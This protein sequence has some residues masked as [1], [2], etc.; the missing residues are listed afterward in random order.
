MS[1]KHEW[2][3][4]IPIQ[5]VFLS[6]SVLKNVYPQGV[7]SFSARSKSRARQWKLAYKEFMENPEEPRL[8]EEWVRFVLVSLDFEP[9]DFLVGEAISR[10]RFYPIGDGKSFGPKYILPDVEDP[11]HYRLLVY[12]ME[13]GRKPDEI[14]DDWTMDVSPIHYV[15]DEL[16]YREEKIALLTNGEDWIIIYAPNPKKYLPGY[17][18]FSA[19]LF[20]ERATEDARDIFCDFLKK[21]RFFNEPEYTPEAMLET[22]LEFQEEVTN[23]LGEQVRTSVEVFLRSLDRLDKERGF[24]VLQDIPP[25]VLYESAL[26][27]M[28]R[29][30]ILLYAEERDLMPKGNIYS[31]NYAITGLAHRL[32]EESVEEEKMAQS[33]DAYPQ[34]LA[35]FRLLYAGL[36]DSQDPILPYG[37]SLLDPDRFPF[38]EGRKAGTSWRDDSTLSHPY[39]VDNRTIHFILKSIQF[40]QKDGELRKVSFRALD[41]EQIGYVYETLLEYTAVRACKDEVQLSY[42]CK[43]G[44]RGIFSLS[45][46]LEVQ[47]KGKLK[48]FLSK[49]TGKNFESKQAPL[50]DTELGYLSSYLGEDPELALIVKETGGLLNRDPIEEKHRYIILPNSLYVAPGEDRSSSGTHYTPRILTSEVVKHTLDPLCYSGPAEGMDEKDWKLKP[51]EDLLELKICDMTVGSGA[52]LVEASRYL[53]EKIL[54]SWKKSGAV[55][56]RNSPRREVGEDSEEELLNYARRLVVEKCLYGVDKNPLAVEMAKLSLWL[57]TFDPKK[58]FTFVDHAI[59]C[60]DSLVGASFSDIKSIN[61]SIKDKKL[62]GLTDSWMVRMFDDSRKLREELE[63]IRSDEPEKSWEKAD[64]WN[65]SQAQQEFLRNACLV[66]TGLRLLG[67]DGDTIRLIFAKTMS[68]TAGDTEKFLAEIASNPVLQ[69]AYRLGL[70]TR[71]FSWELEFPEVFDRGEKSGFDAFVGN[72]PFLGGQKITGALSEDYRE[73]IVKWIANNKK[74]AADLVAYFFLKVYD[75][76]NNNG[77]AGLLASKSIAQGV[78]NF[79]SLETLYEK[80]VTIFRASPLSKW[81]GAANTVISK[82]MFTRSKWRGSYFIDS[83]QVESISYKLKPSGINSIKKPFTL[84]ECEKFAFQGSIPLGGKDDGFSLRKEEI[85]GIDLSASKNSDCIYLHLIGD[86]INQNKYQEASR[87]IINFFDWPL[88]RTAEG[89]WW[90]DWKE[91]KALEK[92]RD[93]FDTGKPIRWMRW[94]EKNPLECTPST[95]FTFYEDLPGIPKELSK[96]RKKW[97]QE[98]RVPSDYPY[99][100]ARDY[101]DLIKIVEEKVKPERDNNNRKER[102]IKWWLYAERSTKLYRTIAGHERVL[103]ISQATKYIQ[104]SHTKNDKVLDQA[105]VIIPEQNINFF[106]ILSSSIHTHWADYF[107]SSLGGTNYYNPTYVLKN[108]PFVDWESDKCK[109]LIQKPASDLELI[110]NEWI[111]SGNGKTDLFNAIHDSSN[112]DSLIERSRLVFKNLDRAVADAY[113]WTDLQLEYDFRE[114]P[115]GIRYTVDEETRQDILDRLLELNHKRHAEELEG[116]KKSPPA[117]KKGKKKVLDEGDG[118]F[119]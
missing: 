50:P 70:E 91:G 98:G 49:E 109:S 113:G 114:T 99:P 41:I 3:S 14:Q 45:E 86:D 15:M 57:A 2:L 107:R 33:Y 77:Y 74:G 20:V 1:R 53:S 78:T 47:K 119:S 13:F 64:L 81:P 34:L 55:G 12:E 56:L 29:I 8:L 23:T 97:L 35:L 39:P 90:E 31:R 52:F 88:E 6:N 84:K 76:M 62:V 65:Q 67:Q 116:E 75:L 25:S 44:K 37:S 100:V 26:F 105:L 104:F 92:K 117:K 96:K 102:R 27:F 19:E 101:P 38:L 89:S 73:Y 40:L 48:E 71:A 80:D 66:L 54:Q 118:L 10:D 16:K 93:S 58:P 115:Q 28:M 17:A 9:N 24:T 7:T 30:V 112:V 85:I 94:Q 83:K 46:L 42:E 11:N 32:W 103:V 108:F 79:V 18:W 68:E 5:G 106:G 110:Y 21:S 4:Y 69:N 95:A 61:E 82:V 72:P 63:S 36:E 59:R 87:Y 22:S 51:A 111:E 60:G 43:P